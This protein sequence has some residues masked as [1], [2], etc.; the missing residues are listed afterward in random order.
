MAKDKERVSASDDADDQ[1]QVDADTT[2]DESETARPKTT[3]GKTP[4]TTAQADLTNDVSRDE[5]FERPITPL[6]GQKGRAVTEDTRVASEK[7]PAVPKLFLQLTQALHL[8][9]SDILSYN[10]NTK[11]VVYANGAKYQLSKNNKSLR[12][13]AGPEPPKDL[14]LKTI[15]ATQRGYIGASALAN[16]PKVATAEDDR[17]AEIE[18]LRSRLAELEAEGEDAEDEE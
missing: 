10:E 1:E 15:D 18:S 5:E 13:L 3:K 7:S 8:K 17:R 12:R 14:K 6:P 16:A 2:S 9:P 4:A 11:T